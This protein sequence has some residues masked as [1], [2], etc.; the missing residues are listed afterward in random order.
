MNKPPCVILVG[1]LPDESWCPPFSILADLRAQGK[2]VCLPARAEHLIPAASYDADGIICRPSRGGHLRLENVQKPHRPLVIGTLSKDWSHI[3]LPN[4]YVKEIIV[5]QGDANAPAVADLTM[6][7]A[8]ELLRPI[9]EAAS[10]MLTYA[11]HFNIDPY[12]HQFD[13]ASWGCVGAG[14]QVRYLLPQ[15]VSRR[16]SDILVFH[17]EMNGRRFTSAVSHLVKKEFDDAD[18]YELDIQNPCGTVTHV[19]GI[20]GIANFNTFLQ[21]P[22]IISLHVPPSSGPKA[23]YGFVTEGLI[24]EKNIEK[25]KRGVYIVNV[26]RGILVK[27]KDVV[28]ALRSGHIGGFAADVVDPDAEFHRE[29]AFS[30]LWQE[31]CRLNECRQVG[32][33]RDLRLFLTPHVG[34]S[35][36]EALSTV[37]GDVLPRFLRAMGIN[38]QEVTYER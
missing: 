31:F 22:D 24:C 13:G 10:E 30:P 37:A 2:I 35:T 19:R 5:A 7:L 3:R 12:S 1:E 32:R 23:T 9:N 11:W 36:V 15:L 25:M 17:P 28:A 14:A 4:N 29:P 26:S 20:G 38:A 18:N 27:E 33:P 16:C 21:I 6:L 8:S 34:S